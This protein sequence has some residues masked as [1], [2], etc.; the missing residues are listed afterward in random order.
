MEFTYNAEQDFNHVT[1]KGL[2][3]LPSHLSLALTSFS[4]VI[5]MTTA[6]THLLTH[7]CH[8]VVDTS[9]DD[10]C[11]SSNSDSCECLVVPHSATNSVFSF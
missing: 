11:T 7:K 2:P 10:L 6:G 5:I 1:R 3:P 9:I 8:W 4:L